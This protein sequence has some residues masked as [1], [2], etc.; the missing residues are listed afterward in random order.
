L[1]HEKGATMTNDT[2]TGAQRIA[3]ERQTVE[4]FAGGEYVEYSGAPFGIEGYR[5]EQL[6]RNEL[7]RRGRTIFRLRQQLKRDRLLRKSG[8]L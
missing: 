3:D 1:E 8:T 4:R 7:N 5:A 6:V 2:R